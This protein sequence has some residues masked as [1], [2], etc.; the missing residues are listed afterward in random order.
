MFSGLKSTPFTSI[1]KQFLSFLLSRTF[2][3]LDLLNIRNSF[4][5]RNWSLFVA[6]PAWNDD[7]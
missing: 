2:C 5:Y 7:G 1:T 6:S 4:I 3:Q